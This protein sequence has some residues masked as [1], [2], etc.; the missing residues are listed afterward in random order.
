MRRPRRCPAIVPPTWPGYPPDANRRTGS[1]QARDLHDDVEVGRAL[2]R[3]DALERG[4][5]VI[6]T[7]DANADVLLVDFLVVGGVVVP[8]PARPGL[9]PGVALPVDGVA[10]LG[11]GVGMQVARHVTRRNPHAAQQDQRQV[12]EVLADSLALA[13][14]VEARGVHAGGAWHVI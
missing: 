1:S 2:A 8:P 9:N 5:V 12:G 11:L 6:V 13:Q 10:D 7:T 4:Y 3:V 14:R